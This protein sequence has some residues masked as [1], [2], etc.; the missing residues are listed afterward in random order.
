VETGENRNH[1]LLLASPQTSRP[2]RDLASSAI[3]IVAEAPT[4][5]VRHRAILTRYS[6]T[7]LEARHVLPALSGNN[8]TA[9]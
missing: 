1:L 8:P 4:R 3:M 6:G 5:R 9:Y 2:L 7:R